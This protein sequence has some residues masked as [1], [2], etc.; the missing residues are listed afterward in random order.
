MKKIMIFAVLFYNCHCNSGRNYNVYGI[1]VKEVTLNQDSVLKN[2]QLVV[3]L[4]SDTDIIEFANKSK[5]SS[6]R[7]YCS[8]KT[9]S[10]ELSETSN[11]KHLIFGDIDENVK[12]DFFDKKKYKIRV[13]I[14]FLNNENGAIRFMT[15]SE[16]LNL[17]NISTCINCQIIASYYMQKKEI[18][19][20]PFCIPVSSVS[21]LIQNKEL[22]KIPPQ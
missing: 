19:S 21:K 11:S 12:S 16:I 13:P 9:D 8:S 5:S 18:Y 2:P 22:K 6:L 10:I 3:E 14:S 15:D 17:I 4:V 7:M 20:E 1:A